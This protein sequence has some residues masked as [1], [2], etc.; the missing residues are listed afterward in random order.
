M[1]DDNKKAPKKV[2]DEV[3]VLKKIALMPDSR[4]VIGESLHKLILETIPT[5]RPRVWYGMPGYAN[6]K[7]GPVLC[8]FRSDKYMTFGLT[9]KAHFDRE[10]GSLH[11]LMPAAWFF[12]ELDSATEEK[13]ADILRNAII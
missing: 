5:M 13:I 6:S 8:Y 9:E 11:N 12:T 2:D 1:K 7:D 4:R 10:E 3:E